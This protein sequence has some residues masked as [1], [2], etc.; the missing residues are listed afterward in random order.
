MFETLFVYPFT[1]FRLQICYMSDLP[2]SYN[3]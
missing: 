2:V 3:L 1:D